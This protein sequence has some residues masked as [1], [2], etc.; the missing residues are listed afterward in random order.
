MTDA[1]HSAEQPAAP[2]TEPA[3][4][5][6]GKLKIFLGAA[7]GVGKT[8]EMLSSAAQRLAAG[9]DVVIG[10]VDTHGQPETEAM[11]ARFERIPRIA[12]AHAAGTL[13]EMDLDAILARAPTLVLIDDYAHANPDACR[14]PRRWQDVE[15]LRDAGIDVYTTLNIQH[16]ES[17][18]D[19]VAGFTHLPVHDT[20][21]D[22]ILDAAE[23]EVVDLPP[24][25]LI[26][27]LKEGKVAVPDDATRAPHY[28]SR[29]NLSA[30]R[31][32]ALRRA[33]MRVDNQM[34]EDLDG[35]APAAPFAGGERV[36]VAIS[37]LPGADT[38]VRTAKR[39][40]DALRAPWTA[41]FVET[42]R[43]E[44]FTADER[45]RLATAFRLAGT[46]GA[47]LVTVPAENVVAGL[48][49]QI[50]GMRATQLV[51]GKS[52]RSW[53][54]E[55]R[56]GS[57]VDRLLRHSEGLAIHVIPAARTGEAAARARGQRTRQRHGSPATYALILLLVAVA[58][59][60][61]ALAEPLIGAGGID[62][63]YLVPTI[64][65]AALYGL[66][67]G[68]ITSVA[69]ALAYNFFFLSPHYTFNVGDPESLF[70]VVILLAVAT[71]ASKLTGQLRS[72]AALGVRSARENAAIAGFAQTLARV[73]DA[74]STA[75][76]ICAEVSHLLGVNA[77]VLVRDEGGVRI[78]RSNPPI[79]RIGPVDVAAADWAFAR[80]EPA[81]RGT[82]TLTAA[83]WQFHPLKTSLGVL[84]VLGIA[85]DDGG[86]PVPSDRTVLLSTLV[87]QA[88]LAHER[89]AL[90]DEMRQLGLLK[91]RDR[92]R[93]ALLSSIGQDL[94]APLDV[95]RKAVTEL[96]G[97]HPESPGVATLVRVI[98]RLGRFLDDLFDM[99]RL[100]G[101]ALTVT[102]EPVDLGEA[103][104]GAVQALRGSLA[105]GRVELAVPPSLPPVMADPR[106]LHH[107]LVNLLAEAAQHGAGRIRVEGARRQGGLSLTVLDDGPTLPAGDGNAVFGPFGQDAARQGSS[108]LA[109]AIVKG[110]ADAMEIAATASSRPEGGAAFTLD[111]PEPLIVR[112]SRA[113]PDGGA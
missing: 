14:H 66:R 3:P 20:V 74:G 58:T 61:A 57:V 110:F 103:V 71:F 7:P 95:A 35:G 102:P 83:D 101:G 39:L 59:G 108:G 36:L 54:F 2:A 62:L 1:T 55:L 107:I 18:S 73:S 81:G 47:T 67:V 94:R 37:E 19:V 89:I 92:L 32:L 98:G 65:V 111:F 84:A 5:P 87:G 40:A 17:L 38:L 68:L 16:I 105:D 26:E 56:H 70:T 4:A 9:V 22:N 79:E 42:P 93:T 85:R 113:R 43:A 31:E 30:L 49:A 46:L 10:V 75:A 50:Q 88:A 27:R 51:I 109:L 12:V 97:A 52:Q 13:E 76:A 45:K 64:G 15:E 23:I 86:D 60:V 72:R 63:V 82:A 25:E 29:P 106:L 24:D 28:F 99:A 34:L 44:G 33:A 100:D 48:V 8:Y 6:R 80:G 78:L 96:N 11:A 112:T 104:A 21:P 77:L 41:V 90:E 53:L 91:A 69:C